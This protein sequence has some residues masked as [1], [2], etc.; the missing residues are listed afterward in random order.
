MATALCTQ[1]VA[2]GVAVD[3][4]LACL[5]ILYFGLTPATALIPILEVDKSR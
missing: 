4:T 2:M 5:D 1:L 3:V